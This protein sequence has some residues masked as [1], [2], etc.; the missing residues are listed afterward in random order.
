MALND[1]VIIVNSREAN[2]FYDACIAFQSAGEEGFDTLEEVQREYQGLTEDDACNY[3]IYGWT[4]QGWL[5]FE[6]KM[7][8]IAGY[9]EKLRDHIQFLEN[10]MDTR[11][12]IIQQREGKLSETQQLEQSNV[13]SEQ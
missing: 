13:Y 2:D 6:S 7:A 4:L 1:P 8:E 5:N 3:N 10:Q 12:E 9:V 11:Y